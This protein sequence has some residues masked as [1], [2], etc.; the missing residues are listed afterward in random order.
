MSSRIRHSTARDSTAPTPGPSRSAPPN[1]QLPP[2]R[3]P[4]HPLNQKAQNHLATLARSQGLREFKEHN[5]QAAELISK[6]AEQINDALRDRESKVVKRRQKQAGGEE[7]E[8]AEREL[9]ELKAKVEDMTTKLEVGMR[10]AIDT[11]MAGQRMEEGFNWMRANAPGQLER[12]YEQQ[13]T[14]RQTQQ[15]QSQRRRTQRDENGDENMDEDDDRSSPG[16][17]PLNEVRIALTGPSELFADRLERKKTEYLS[18]PHSV[19]YAKNND[20]IGFKGVVHDSRFGDSGPALPHP[21]TW[22]TERG[23][24]APGITAAQNNAD[25]DD[26]I[27]VDKATISTRCPLTYQKFREP[28][29]SKKCPHSFEK[30]AILEYI[31]KS[32]VKIGGGPGRGV[33]EKASEC[34]VS[35]CDQVGT[36]STFFLQLPRDA[37]G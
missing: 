35:G 7:Q 18:L 11:E 31:R 32:K 19:R 21:D 29:T 16:P 3:K 12:E 14:Q 23:S 33:G 34:P 30:N 6:C 4:S 1:H 13:L 22:F 27:V 15:S 2:Y 28:L 5:K 8:L 37:L 36:P 24:P 20:Y 17:T 10:E 25:D 9:E 26:D